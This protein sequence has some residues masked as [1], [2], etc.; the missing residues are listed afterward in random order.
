MSRSLCPYCTWPLDK[1]QLKLTVKELTAR[2]LLDTPHSPERDNKLLLKVE[3]EG[4][5]LVPN[6]HPS[7]P[8]LMKLH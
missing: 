5:I 7:T 6:T 8:I 4:N 3:S 2:L 1:Q